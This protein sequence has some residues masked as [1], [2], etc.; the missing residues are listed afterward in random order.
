MKFPGCDKCNMNFWNKI[1][2]D[3]LPLDV[4]DFMSVDERFGTVND[5]KMLI[6]EAHQLNMHFTMDLPISTTSL[7]H[8][9]FESFLV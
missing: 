6:D 8:S 1:Q 7:Y 2:D 3:F 5:L 4:I 9:W